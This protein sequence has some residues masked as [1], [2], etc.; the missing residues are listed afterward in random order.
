MHSML[1]ALAFL[2]ILPV[3]FR[4]LP[5]SEIVARSRWW[6]PVV[7]LLLGASLGTWTAVLG[8]WLTSPTLV[9]FL[10]L[11]AWVA[12]TGALHIDGF[13]DVCDGLFGGHT[14]EDRLRIMKDPHLGTF[15]LVG[16]VLLLLGKFV[17]LEVLVQ[18][19]QGPWVVGTAVVAARC[20]VLCV[21]AG[22]RYPRPEGTGKALIEATGAWEGWLF[23]AVAAVATLLALALPRLWD[24][25]QLSWTEVRTAL[26]L[27][28][29]AFLTVMGLKWQC[30][31]RLGGITGDCLGAAIE[32]AEVVF[33]LTAAV[34]TIPC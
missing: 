1:V 5:S 17:A 14:P 7:G 31:R 16:G 4:A 6:Y 11:L 32:A 22:S 25:D 26:E 24:N 13:C 23:A 29:V 28:S 3:R 10:V 27:F 20:L 30:V 21:A 2:T 9:A 19:R 33:L 18:D 12:L 15:G 8:A 34:L